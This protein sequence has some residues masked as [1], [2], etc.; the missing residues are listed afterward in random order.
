[1][2]LG[3][4]LLLTTIA[5]VALIGCSRREQVSSDFV[6]VTPK[7][8]NPDGHP[9][10]ALHY[11]GAVVWPNVYTGSGKTYHD[12]IFVFSAPV[13][14]GS[15]NSDGIPM[16]DYSISP[17]LFAIRG[18]GPPIIISERILADTLDSQKRYRLW[19]VT[20]T[21]SGLRTEFEYWPDKDHQ[22]RTIRDVPWA[23]IRSWVQ[24]AESSVPKKVTPLGTYRVLPLKR[25]NQSAA[26]DR[27]PVW[28][29]GGLDNLSTALAA[30][31]VFASA[32]AE[33]LGVIH[34]YA[35]NRNQVAA[36]IRY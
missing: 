12:G 25:P 28:Q 27:R 10:T 32:V 11:K 36:C 18:A 33:S 16:Y 31:R 3:T 30:D 8:W 26:P 13:P 2:R 7:S 20:P 24:E 29:P 9:G 35:D 1:M 4:L 6:L 22:A 21:E 23:D 15:T 17:Q 19:Q 5:L 34:K 14:D